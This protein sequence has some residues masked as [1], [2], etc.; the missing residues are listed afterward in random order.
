MKKTFLLIATALLCTL[1]FA[2]STDSIL[3]FIKSAPARSRDVESTFTEVHTPAAKNAAKT[4]LKGDLSFKN[5]CLEMKYTNGDFFSTDNV[6][7]KKVHGKAKQEFDLTKNQ[8]M[9]GLSHTLIFSFQGDPGALAAE[10]GTEISATKDGANYIVTLVAK[11]KTPRGL[12]K[13][14]LVYSAADGAIISMQM[15]ECSGASTFYSL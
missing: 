13:L 1:T 6:K 2:Q 15:D 11:K 7:M 9:K 8:M 10:Q 14:V 12:S 5:N 3:S 4:T